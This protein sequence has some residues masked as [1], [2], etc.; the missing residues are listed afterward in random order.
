MDAMRSKNLDIL[1]KT[2]SINS[3]I[4]KL[5]SQSEIAHKSLE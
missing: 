2:E 1:E 3:K 4:I 5:K